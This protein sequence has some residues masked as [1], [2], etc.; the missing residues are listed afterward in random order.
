MED[1]KD[2]KKCWVAPNFTIYGD[3]VSL[4]QG[5][6]QC[7]RTGFADDL[8]QGISNFPT[9]PGGVCPSQ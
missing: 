6:V 3:V 1:V 5:Q 4:T 8:A 9:G 7:K 2:Q